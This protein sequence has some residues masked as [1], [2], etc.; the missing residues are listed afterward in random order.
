MSV[1]G[2]GDVRPLA[3]GLDA[4]MAA[5]HSVEQPLHAIGEAA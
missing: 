3:G 4:W 5:S 1:R 2:H